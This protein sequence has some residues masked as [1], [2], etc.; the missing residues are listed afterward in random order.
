MAILCTIT[1]HVYC[2]LPFYSLPFIH[3]RFYLVCPT[4]LKWQ[5]PVPRLP[6]LAEVLL[7][8]VHGDVV[9]DVP[10]ADEERV[11]VPLEQTEVVT[12]GRVAREHIVLNGVCG[13]RRGRVSNEEIY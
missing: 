5:T 11:S 3:Y 1:P 8:A 7:Q 4:W 6:H 2:S 10:G 12:D 13:R 9:D